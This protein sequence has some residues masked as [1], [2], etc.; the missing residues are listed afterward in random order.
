M[1]DIIFYTLLR[2]RHIP[3]SHQIQ[4]KDPIVIEF[5]N[6]VQVAGVPEASNRVTLKVILN[7]STILRMGFLREGTSPTLH[8]AQLMRDQLHNDLYPKLIEAQTNYLMTPSGRN[9]L[10]FYFESSGEGGIDP[11]Y[12]FI[13]DN[14][15]NEIGRIV[16][17]F[18]KK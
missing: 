13:I 9:I 15:N 18:P 17:Y 7:E 11:R 14:F 10:N 8:Q 5:T 16:V 1:V 3:P 2:P 12:K 6:V 4:H